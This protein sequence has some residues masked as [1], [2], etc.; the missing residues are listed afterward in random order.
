MAAVLLLVGLG[1]A[2][3]RALPREVVAGLVLALAVTGTVVAEHRTIDERDERLRDLFSLREVVEQDPTAPVV[4]V[5]D[6]PLLLTGTAFQYWLGDREYRLLDPA[7]EAVKIR[8]GELVIGTLDPRPLMIG[9][10]A[11]SHRHRPDQPLRRVEGA[12]RSGRQRPVLRAHAAGPGPRGS[13]PAG[14]G[15]Q[16]RARRRGLRQ[17]RDVDVLRDLQP[18]RHAA[19]VPVQVH[20]AGPRVDGERVE[21]P[22]HP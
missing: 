7:Q 2:R 15:S 13:G 20:A 1:W 3:A 17:A 11:R 5:V 21:H 14:P 12:R 22:V 16:A 18:E 4:L 8:P 19:D 6:R 10:P 9:A